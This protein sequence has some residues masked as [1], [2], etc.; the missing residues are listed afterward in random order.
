MSPRREY[1]IISEKEWAT[2]DAMA[3]YQRAIVLTN[4]MKRLCELGKSRGPLWRDH[5][6]DLERLVPSGRWEHYKS[7]PDASKYYLVVGASQ[8]TE[9]P[10]DF[11]VT[12]AAEYAPFAG[13]VAHRPLFGN[14]VRVSGF[15]DPVHQAGSARYRFRYIKGLGLDVLANR[16]EPPSY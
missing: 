8:S 12:Y 2:L 5:K 4:E 9:P 11:V 14:G 15:L 6:A 3:A 10:Y 13:I 16:L 1:N 7:T